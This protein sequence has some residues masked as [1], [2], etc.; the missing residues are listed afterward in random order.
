MNTPTDEQPGSPDIPP[1]PVESDHS[2]I[3][4]FW[5]RLLALFLDGLCLGLL[6]LVLGLLLFDPL[7]RLGGW[8]RLIGF[9]VSLA[10]FGLLNSAIG[11]GQTIGKRVMKIAVVDRTGNHLSLARSLVRYAVLGIPFFLNG[12]M[13]PPNVMVSPIGYL[14]GFILFGVGGAII[15]LYVFN[16][17]TRQSLHDLVVGSFVTRKTSEGR[18][19]GSMWR[20]HLIVIAVW[21]VAVVGLSVVTTGLTKKGIFPELLSVQSAIQ[22]SG[23]VHMVS[24]VAGKSWSNVG[25]KRS[26][27]TYLQSNAIWKERPSDSE[28]AARQVAS[29]ILQNYPGV[30]D[31]DVLA[32]T[33]TYGYDIGIARA[34]RTQRLQHSPSEWQASLSD[35]SAQ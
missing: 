20:P 2:I 35:P 9:S 25:G 18:I 23:K 27:T 6:G 4:G 34:W 22:S 24:V 11:K 29:L 33:I 3:C 15:Y 30:V 8:G 17:R 28:E 5:S 1:V 19:V 10:Y 31:K 7:S 32:V 16:R 21:L 12:A 26:E 13:I 14:I